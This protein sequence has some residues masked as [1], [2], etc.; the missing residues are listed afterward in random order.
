MKSLVLVSSITLVALIIL[1]T[2]LVQRRIERQRQG[3]YQ[4]FC[5]ERGYQYVARRPGA[6][7]PYAGVVKLFNRGSRHRWRDEISG[8]YGEVPFTAFEYLY[9]ISTGK[10]SRTYKFAMIRWEE[11]SLDLPQFALAPEGFFQRVGQLFGA[12]DIDFPED[13]V[14]SHEYV[15]KGID[16]AA[17][18]ALFTAEVRQAL[19]A[20]RGQNVAGAG[21]DLFWWQERSLPPPAEFDTFL[22]AGDSIRRLF[23]RR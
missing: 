12:Q 13:P 10:S 19:D 7:R 14:F 22:Q 1:A 9:T 18:R 4:Q 3:A 17:V 20:A 15:L 5:N 21:P 23:I 6:E 11:P 2:Y 16:E 8:Q